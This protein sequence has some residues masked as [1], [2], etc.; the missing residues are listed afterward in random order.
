M[1][2]ACFLLVINTLYVVFL[3][4]LDRVA[5]LITDPPPTSF[6]TLYEKKKKKKYICI[7]TVQELSDVQTSLKTKNKNFRAALPPSEAVAPLI[8]PICSFVR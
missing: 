7:Y 1:K 8:N 6:T 5:P 3:Y 2:S 4:E